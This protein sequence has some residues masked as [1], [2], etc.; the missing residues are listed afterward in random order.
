[1]TTS[2]HFLPVITTLITIVIHD[3]NLRGTKRNTNIIQ[4]G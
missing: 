3:Y 2:T 1:M 4:I